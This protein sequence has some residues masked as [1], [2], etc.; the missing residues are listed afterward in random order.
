LVIS[1]NSEFHQDKYDVSNFPSRTTP[2]ANGPDDTPSDILARIGGGAFNLVGGNWESVS[3]LAKVGT[4]QAS[5]LCKFR[6]FLYPALILD[7][8]SS[9]VLCQLDFYV[10]SVNIYIRQQ[11]DLVSLGKF[12]TK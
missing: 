7:S 4:S 9:A 6:E 12:F 1:T 11:S 2:F 8:I 3:T 10:S 5:G